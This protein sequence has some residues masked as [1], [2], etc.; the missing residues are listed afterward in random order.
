MNYTVVYSKWAPQFQ[1]RAWKCKSKCKRQSEKKET[2]IDK[3]AYFLS[4]CMK[5]SEQATHQTTR[6]HI[7]TLIPTH[8]HTNQGYIWLRHG[9]YTNDLGKYV[10]GIWYAV[11]MCKCVNV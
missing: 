9:Y 11:N 10:Y 4:I 6:K 1:N 3:K 8:T 2:L 7:L 5:Y